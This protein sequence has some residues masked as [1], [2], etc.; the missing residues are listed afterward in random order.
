M[1]SK[2]I[3]ELTNCAR[4]VLARGVVFLPRE[5]ADIQRWICKIRCGCFATLLH[6]KHHETYLPPC[7]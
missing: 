5:R 7:V 3:D 4:M 2:D 6:Q 1:I